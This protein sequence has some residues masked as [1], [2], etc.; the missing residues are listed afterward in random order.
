M[1]CRLRAELKDSDSDS[2]SFSAASTLGVGGHQGKGQPGVSWWQSQ[3]PALSRKDLINPITAD[4]ISTFTTPRSYR[5]Q[6]LLSSSHAFHALPQGHTPDGL[7][8]PLS[9]PVL[10]Q[11]SA[12]QGMMSSPAQLWLASPSGPA[13]TPWAPLMYAL[14]A[15]SLC[16]ADVQLQLASSP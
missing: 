4:A 16:A 5:L 10:S 1:A 11:S 14:P 2:H 12:L 6:H 9:S 7:Q 13:F 15:G 8:V 3:T